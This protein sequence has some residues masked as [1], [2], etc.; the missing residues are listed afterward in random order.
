MRAQVKLACLACRASKIRCDGRDP[1]ASCI[2]NQRQCH[3]RASR[4]GGARRGVRYENASRRDDRAAASTP[5]SSHQSTEIT[6]AIL[7]GLIS[8][9]SP[10][11]ILPDVS[12]MDGLDRGPETAEARQTPIDQQDTAET[13]G[14]HDSLVVRA[15]RCEED[16]ANAYYIYIHPYFPMLPQPAIPQYQDNP[17]PI[18]TQSTEPDISQ[19]PFWPTTPLGLALMAILALIPVLEDPHPMREQAVRLR[20]SY[21]ETFARAALKSI[22]EFVEDPNHH[23]ASLHSSLHS[24]VPLG[25]ESVLAL[26]LLSLYEYCHCG[27]R[28]KMRSRANLALTTAMDMSLHT[29]SPE[30]AESLNAKRRAWWATIFLVYQSS[31]SNSVAPIILADDPRITTPLTE[32]RCCLEPWPLLVKAQDALYKSSCIVR[33]LSEESNARLSIL[34]RDRIRELDTHLV[35]LTAESDSC[36]CV[37]NQ[38]GAEASATRAMW[39]IARA[40]IHTSRIKLHRLRAF[41]CHPFLDDYHNPILSDDMSL[42]PSP[43][44]SSTRIAEIE[45]VF[46]F[47][48]QESTTTCLKSSLTIS[49][50]FRHLP[51]PNPSYSDSE[52]LVP[53][54][55]ARRRGRGRPGPL[56]YTVCCEV[57]S[58]CVLMML[59]QRVRGC[60]FSGDCMSIR[61]LLGDPRPETE[62]QDVERVCEELQNGIEALVA[63]LKRGEVFDRVGCLAR[64]VEGVYNAFSDR[65]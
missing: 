10:F 65:I 19:L 58:V 47:T 18:S 64:E 37:T 39:V 11:S 28:A 44:L 43:R 61:F 31:I 57:E 41:L 27:S 21:A 40:F 17:V 33:E 34:L 4:R 15:Y 52:F 60:S 49:R 35:A 6:D 29:V 13:S 2:S 25:L 55:Y 32:F 16:L 24:N 42:R 1:C 36:Q 62:K 46:P 48:E 8:P 22:Q 38:Q 51:P 7:G 54:A 56:P 14:S 63:A 12:D 5:S 50:I 3:Y 23:A 45:A 30:A 59:L 53:A 20:R 26:L 9:M